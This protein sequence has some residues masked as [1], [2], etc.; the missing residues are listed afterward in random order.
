MPVEDQTELFERTSYLLRKKVGK[1]PAIRLDP[2]DTTVPPYPS[3]RSSALS[4]IAESSRS[5]SASRSQSRISFRTPRELELPKVA[6]QQLQPEKPLPHAPRRSPK[7]YI[8]D[9]WQSPGLLS[10]RSAA[11]LAGVQ[12]IVETYLNTHGHERPTYQTGLIERLG[13]TMDDN[14]LE[15]Q[16]E[17]TRQLPLALWRKLVTASCVAG[18]LTVVVLLITLV[19]VEHLGKGRASHFLMGGSGAIIIFGALAMIATRRPLT[20]VLIMGV[21]GVLICQ[22]VMDD[23]R[24]VGA[25]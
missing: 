2:L 4:S 25:G 1:Q 15:A 12:G 11:F 16:K 23:F 8:R 9:W 14:N 21:L 24:H 5:F 6:H 7:E 13:G 20:E 18:M 22:C 19:S 3:N 10:A 17:K